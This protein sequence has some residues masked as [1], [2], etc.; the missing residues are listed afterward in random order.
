[1]AKDLHTKPFDE[2][3]EQKLALLQSYIKEWLPVFLRGKPM[4][5]HI[6]DFFAGPGVSESG[7]PGS[8]VMILD[9]IK[10]YEK[11]IR[12]NKIKVTL[13]LNDADSS[14]IEKLKK[15]IAIK[16]PSIPVSVIFESLDFK[17]AF[18]KWRPSMLGQPNFIFLDQNGIKHI[19]KALFLQLIQLSY[20]D[21]LFFI[22]SSYIKRFYAEPE[23]QNNLDFDVT[24]IANATNNEAHR[25]T[26]DIYR[27]FIPQ[28]D[29]FYV[30]HFSLKKDR[31]VY[32]LIYGS[33]SELGILKFLERCWN[34]DPN[35]GEANY[36]IDQD[37]SYNKG[38][39]ILFE[40][41]KKPKKLNRFELEI[42][43]KIMNGSFSTDK[44][45]LLYALS[46]GFIGR[47]FA[48]IISSLQKDGLIIT[49]SSKKLRYSRDCLK[50][51]RTFKIKS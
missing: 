30:A 33:Q 18:T 14:K 34:L 32:G 48:E 28:G 35:T 5:I 13:Y 11:D 27:S 46:S 10:D 37:L 22:S 38:Q 36:N 39:E 31:N 21:F 17:D 1:M 8:P 26:A 45:I 51:P 3:T 50:E 19:T 23:F 2:G 16:Y 4:N 24:P 43:E 47:H 12:V 29:K 15:L 7:Q 20:T 9:A 25:A 6:Y 44:E 41:M 42:S 40:E 49:D